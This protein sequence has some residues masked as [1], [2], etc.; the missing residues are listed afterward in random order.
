MWKG[1]SG[2]MEVFETSLTINQCLR[3]LRVRHKVGGEKE[4]GSVD[5][6]N[7]DSISEYLFWYQEG[8]RDSEHD[9]EKYP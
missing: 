9:F 5:V 7:S 1:G 3:R 2:W 6:I 8:K 4:E